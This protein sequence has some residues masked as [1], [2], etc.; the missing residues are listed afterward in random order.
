MSIYDKNR[1][2]EMTIVFKPDVSTIE[3]K[4]E[5]SKLFKNYSIQD[6]E[7]PVYEDDGIK[8]LA[9]STKGYD[10]G[11]YVFTTG[12]GFSKDVSSAVVEALTE[13][14]KILRFLVVPQ[15][16]PQDHKK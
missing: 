5:V 7:L 2:W 13:N 6:E 9:Y 11:H 1:V 12:K 15:D 10:S 16:M 4:S 3:A 14:D 8:R